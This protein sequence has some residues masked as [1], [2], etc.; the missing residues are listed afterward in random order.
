[1]TYSFSLLIK[2]PLLESGFD[3]GGTLTDKVI[4]LGEL[5]R[6]ILPEILPLN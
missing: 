4:D 1:M 6:F 2:F 5:F 3:K